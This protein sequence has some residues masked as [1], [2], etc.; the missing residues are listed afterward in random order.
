MKRHNRRDFL[1]AIGIGVVSLTLPGCTN[2]SQGAASKDSRPNILWILSE[3][4]SPDLSCYGTAAVQT[5]NLDK[6]T[7]QGIRFSNAFTTSPVCSASRSAMITG[8]YQTSIGAHNHRSHR[9]DGYTLPEP[10][11]LITEYF[12]QAGDFT[13]NVKTAAPGVRGSGK[14]DFNFKFSNAFDG[15][16]WNQRKPGQ[17][18][19]AQLSISMTHRGGQWKDLDKKLDNPVDPAKVKLPPYYPDHPIARQDWATYLNSI[20]MMDQYVG[21]ILKRLDDEDMA[22][23]TVVI[24]IGDHGRCHVRGKQWL[25]DGGIHI[26]LIIRWPGKLKAGQLCHNFV[27]AIDISA[28][29]LKI[30]GVKPPKHIEGKVFLAPDTWGLKGTWKPVKVRDYIIAARDRCD[31]TI[32]RIRCVRTK[33]YKYIR[34]FMPER[35]YTQTN[36]YKER[37][38]PMMNLMK[39]LHAEGKLT[40]VQALF[41]APRK[42]DEELYDIRTD[43][44]EIHNLANS[45][46]YQ[47]TLEKMRMTLEKWIEDTSDMGRFPEKKSSIT[48]RDRKRIYGE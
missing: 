15:S 20:Q 5:P 25:Y 45:P 38:Y 34:N 46:K 42:P 13:A 44:Y 9:D 8:M 6:L 33:Q 27:S 21:K 16:D 18:F 48:P 35:P 31:E 41:M 26:P 43:P 4:I 36:A 14:T 40:S 12:R 30:A 29:A 39:E 2:G 28:T 47:Q 22:N 23:N 37:S 1:K 17:P 10:V 19:F 24:F 32:D 3:D 7:R 11:R